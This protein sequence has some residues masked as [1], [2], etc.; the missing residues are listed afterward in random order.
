MKTIFFNSQFQLLLLM[1]IAVTKPAWAK[2]YNFNDLWRQAQAESAEMKKEQAQLNF[3]QLNKTRQKLHFTPRVYLKGQSYTTNDPGASFFALLSQRKV[4]PSTDFSTTSLNT[5]GNTTLSQATLGL[6]L[7][8]YKGGQDGQRSKAAALMFQAQEFKTKGVFLEV[9]AQLTYLYAELLNQQKSLQ[10][11]N[12]LQ[13]EINQQ[14]N[15]YQVG[16]RKNP[17]GYSGLLG[18]KS[19]KNKI[20][21]TIDMTNT[22][23]HNLKENIRQYAPSLP[24]NYQ[25]KYEDPYQFINTK[26][27]E[28]TK[29]QTMLPSY[30]LTSRQLMEESLTHKAE[31]SARRWLPQV[32]AFG[33][34]TY[35]NGDRDSA[36]S[37]SAGVYLEWQ[38]SIQNYGLNNEVKYQKAI[39]QAETER[40]QRFE[41]AKKIEGLN[42]IQTLKTNIERVRE[43]NEIL[44]EQVQ[45]SRRLFHNGAINAIQLSE[46]CSRRVDAQEAL[47]QIISQYLQV[48]TQL[49]Q[50]SQQDLKGEQP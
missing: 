47:T 20:V 11:L 26:I 40:L 29:Q 42:S 19:L 14:I 39:E 34:T 15:T 32:G 44:T 4:S 18:L 49:Y 31:A 22:K 27:K 3:T 24:S 35:Y 10:T 46:V 6:Q 43:T 41:Y 9:Y 28:S 12:Q 50:Y 30:M 36:D 8:I 2:E 7:P 17:V 33:E 23:I 5:P 38:W 37:Y 1:L 48:K 16:K 25:I 13:S 21:V 45:I